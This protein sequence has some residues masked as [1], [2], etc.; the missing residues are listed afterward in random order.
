M[1][2][3]PVDQYTTLLSRE[4]QENDEYVII[5]VKWLEHWIYIVM[6]NS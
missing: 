5:D 2:S 1:P 6:L 4:Q 3:N